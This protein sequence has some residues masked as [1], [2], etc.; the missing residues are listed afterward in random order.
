MNLWINDSNNLEVSYNF[1]DKNN[2]NRFFCRL[3][4]LNAHYTDI[5]LYGR[6]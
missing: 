1:I 4:F 3:D 2:S 5:L 6:L